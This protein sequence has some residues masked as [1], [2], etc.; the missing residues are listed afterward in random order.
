[1][2]RV[3][4]VLTPVRV[5]KAFAA[6]TIDPPPLKDAPAEPTNRHVDDV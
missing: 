6:S 5:L 1:L 2:V 4:A 3:A